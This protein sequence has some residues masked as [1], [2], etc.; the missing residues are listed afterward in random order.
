M[1]VKVIAIGPDFAGP[2]YAL[3]VEEGV[4]LSRDHDYMACRIVDCEQVVALL[5]EAKWKETAID[6]LLDNV[7]DGGFIDVEGVYIDVDDAEPHTSID[8]MI[9]TYNERGYVLDDEGNP[10]EIDAPNSPLFKLGLV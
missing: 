8:D 5:Q 10:T 4:W 6:A 3:T 7:R 1:K 9:E 2:G